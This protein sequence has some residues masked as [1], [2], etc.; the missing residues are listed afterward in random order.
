MNELEA[1]LSKVNER[2]SFPSDTSTTSHGAPSHPSDDPSAR[3]VLPASAN[4]QFSNDGAKYRLTVDSD[5]NVSHLPFCRQRSKTGQLKIVQ[6]VYHGLTSLDQVD[7]MADLDAIA[8]VA[9]DSLGLT[10]PAF[11]T[12]FQ[13]LAMSKHISV[14]PELG[15]ALIDSFF[16]HQTLAIVDR[17]VFLRDM[18]LEGPFFSEFLLMC[19]Y[20]SA[21]R[22]IDCLDS[23]ER[24]SQDDLFST[25]ARNLLTK[26]LEGP[27]RITTAQGLL[28]L[29]IRDSNLGHISQSWN[30]AGLVR[31][32]ACHPPPTL[33]VV[34]PGFQADT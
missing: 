7:D 13:H 16:C 9:P 23:Q 18:A 8:P 11:A 10:E 14:A 31:H 20:T 21:N 27:S 1:Q 2:L 32:C 15:Q 33:T 30:Y 34:S 26:Q 28:L 22:M 24:Q 19:I 25:L 6:V 5:G 12:L 3:E 4:L 17:S 29:S